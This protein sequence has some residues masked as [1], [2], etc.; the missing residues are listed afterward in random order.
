M[1]QSEIVPN[2][3]FIQNGDNVYL[4]KHYI[5]KQEINVVRSNFGE[6]MTFSKDTYYLR[7][8]ERDSYFKIVFADRKNFDGQRL[9]VSTYIR[10]YVD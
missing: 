7:T 3:D 6:A 4:T 10:K 9:S 1:K 8:E 5:V 2:L